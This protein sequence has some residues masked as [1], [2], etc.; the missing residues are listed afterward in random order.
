MTDTP[1]YDAL[2]PRDRALV[3]RYIECGFVQSRAYFDV[4]YQGEA[5]SHTADT[6]RTH[7]SRR[8]A[9]ANIREAIS[10]RVAA[11]AMGA[12]EALVR[13]AQQAENTASRYITSAGSVDMRRLIDDGY[14]HLIKGTKWDRDGNL[15]VELYDAQSAL[16]TILQATGALGAKGTADDP[17][18]IVVRVVREDVGL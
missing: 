11:R 10:E 13:L 9:D 17:S 3:D 16:K 5:D 12:D 18:N 4:I 2:A 15:V 7:A 6:V 1:A 8:F 14:G